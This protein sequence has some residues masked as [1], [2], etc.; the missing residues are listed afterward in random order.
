MKISEV[1]TAVVKDYINAPY[2]TEQVINM[3]VTA[4]KS[5]ILQ[6]T[7]INKDKLDEYE[8]LTIVLLILCADFY[9]QRQF[10]MDSNNGVP[11]NV[12]V[13]SILGQYSFNLV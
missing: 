8:D 1:T 3:L 11:T 2:E 7:G 12:I 13:E 10:I 9:D 6:Q 5:Y 4:A